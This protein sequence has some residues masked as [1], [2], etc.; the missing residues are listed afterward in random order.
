MRVG[1]PTGCLLFFSPIFIEILASSTYNIYT[2]FYQRAM[3]F[4]ALRNSYYFY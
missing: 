2:I 4:I 1:S 3:T